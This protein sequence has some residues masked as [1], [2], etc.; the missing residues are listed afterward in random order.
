MLEYI[1]RIAWFHPIT[2][3]DIRL[4]LAGKGTYLNYRVD[5]VQTIF[6]DN[7]HRRYVHRIK[8]SS[9]YQKIADDLPTVGCYIDDGGKNG[10]YGIAVFY[11]KDGDI[12]HPDY[13]LPIPESSSMSFDYI[14]DEMLFT[15]RVPSDQ[16]ALMNLSQV[17]GF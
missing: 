12:Y 10:N 6:D 3:A 13:F 7:S 9:L 2:V 1:M 16:T 17:G 15:V 5:Q 11:E 4:V 14:N 8:Q